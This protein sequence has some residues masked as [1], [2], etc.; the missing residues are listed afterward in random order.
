MRISLTL[1]YASLAVSFAV[2]APTFDPKP[3]GEQNYPPIPEWFTKANIGFAFAGSGSL[4]P[5]YLGVAYVLVDSGAIQRG[6]TPIGGLSGGALTGSL[7]H[8]MLD[9]DTLYNGMFGMV[10]ACYNDNPKLPCYQTLYPHIVGSLDKI[11]PADI[12]ERTI[13][14]NILRVAVSLLDAR[15]PGFNNSVPM[16][17]GRVKSKETMLRLLGSTTYIPCASGPSPYTLFEGM[18]VMDG[19]FTA[20][21]EHLC[22]EGVDI[23]I[24]VGTYYIGPHTLTFGGDQDHDCVKNEVNPGAWP[25]RAVSHPFRSKQDLSLTKDAEAWNP[26]NLSAPFTK[27]GFLP[28]GCESANNIPYAKPGQ[29][30]IYPGK[31]PQNPIPY[32]CKNWQDLSFAPTPQDFAN[33]VKL[34]MQDARLWLEELANVEGP[35]QQDGQTVYSAT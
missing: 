26:K 29:A 15:Q 28:Q 25:T 3:T 11:F 19:G 35:S 34:G 4:L 33:M 17:V 32:T 20:K 14:K 21:Y 18:P 9:F 7:I 10:E 1:L 13:N 23:C 16:I 24:K 5:Y 12:H 30:N 31:Y 6:V 22:P 8:S 27:F 2:E